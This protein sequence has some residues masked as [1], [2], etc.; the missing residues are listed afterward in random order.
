M[1]E[2]PEPAIKKLPLFSVI[3]MILSLCGL[4]ILTYL[5]QD[6]LDVLHIDHMGGFLILILALLVCLVGGAFGLEGSAASPTTSS[7]TPSGTAGGSC[8]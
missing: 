5:F 7:R 4:T 8:S 1:S 2:L 3:G 6:S